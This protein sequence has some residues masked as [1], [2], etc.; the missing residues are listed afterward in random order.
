MKMLLIEDSAAD[1]ELTIAELR[2][3]GFEPECLRVES[4]EAIHAAMRG[5]TWSFV[6]SDFHLR[7]LHGHA[8]LEI[9][10]RYDAE[11]PFVIVSNS[12][13]EEHAAE[14][15][16]A[17]ASDYVM[18]D[19]LYRLGPIVERE[20]RDV[21]LRHERRMFFDAL[22]RSED[23]YRRIFEKAPIGVATT[24]THGDLIAVNERFASMLEHR[25]HE[26]IGRPLAAFVHPGDA[27]VT[28]AQQRA[29]QRYRTK[30]GDIVWTTVTAAEVYDGEAVLEQIVWLIEDISDQKR[31][32]LELERRA[33]QQTMVAN[34]GH[35]ALRGEPIE[36]LLEQITE[37][38]VDV[39]GVDY[40]GVLRESDG[41]FRRVNGIGWQ[42]GVVIEAD[43]M[44][45]A[46]YALDSAAPVVVRNLAEETRF[47]PPPALLENGIVSGVNVPIAMNQVAAWGVLGVYSRTE[48]SFTIHD[49]GFIRAMATVLAQAIERDRVNQELV[50]HAAQQSAI[51]A[52]TRVALNSIDE[53]IE[54]ACNFVQD[55]LDVERVAFLPPSQPAGIFG[56]RDLWEPVSSTSEHFGVLVAH[57][58]RN[59]AFTEP[60]FEFLRAIANI[61]ADAM[62]RERAARA[63]SISRERYREVVEGAS[64][65]IFT[66][67]P[68]DGTFLSL[69]AAFEQITGWPTSEWIGKSCLEIIAATH[70]DQARNLIEQLVNAQEPASGELRI[71][72]RHGDVLLDINSFPKVEDGR[73]LEI[74][75]FARN[76]TEARRAE[77]ERNEVTRRLQLVLAS[78]VEGIVTIDLAG[79]CTMWNAAATQILGR[80]ND[81]M[82]GETIHSLLHG[83]Y[84]ANATCDLTSTAANGD[85]QPVRKDVFS[86]ADGTVV[87]V[88][89]S[90]APV[91]DDGVTVG[92][93]L[94]FSDITERRNLEMKLDQAD[95]LTSLGRMAATIAHEFNNVL[96]GISPFVEVIRRGKSVETSLDHIAR[97]VKRGKRITDEI[98][99]FTRHEQPQRIAFDIKPWIDS[100]AL[101]ASSLVPANCRIETILHTPNLVID[102]DANQLQQIFTNLILNARDAMPNGGQ[103]TIEAC[104]EP[105]GARLPFGIVDH[106]ERF[107]HCIV[108][109]TGIGMSEETLRHLYEPLYTTKKNG[110]G[111]GLPLARQVVQRHG[112]DIFV[113]SQ[114]GVGTTFHIFLPL[115]SEAA[116]AAVLEPVVASN[117]LHVLLVEDDPSVA[118]GLAALLEMEGLHVDIVE[119]GEAAIAAIATNT[120]DVVVLDVGLPDMQGTK[121][122]AVIAETMP[123]LPV[124]F[125]TGHADR[126]ILDG[127]LELPNVSYLLKPYEGNALLKAIQEVLPN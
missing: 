45:M 105:H 9:V 3:F 62:E 25:P 7:E 101:E 78:T 92:V 58:K 29:E 63:L 110:T 109:D 39:L 113:E 77:N 12:M 66:L 42:E 83:Q 8:A 56:A 28:A 65:I 106:P 47:T 54:T 99:R 93:V 84:C 48:R 111:L 36:V 18:K 122:Y 82:D 71:K 4:A 97:A 17:G 15:I 41:R 61:L 38:V 98:L 96:M 32:K 118:S 22:R 76:V 90:A 104:R 68:E 94:N 70:R 81:E 26:M 87:P 107:A 23:R 86:R 73:T 37:A 75:G 127:L 2:R 51:A 126:A 95:R 21:Q 67:A 43:D 53:A 14:I 121:V 5:V 80:S 46:R 60:D 64:E 40:C 59:G 123:D 50:L 72:G 116:A 10:R 11:L 125:S 100:I 27:P 1:A 115:A 74:Y 117:A 49:V 69:N 91:V 13:G 31:Q 52:L 16:R 79:C 102:G 124:V 112:G 55:V 33:R 114:L 85:V 19:R 44:A 103:L 120:P 108:R 24:T 88:E 57:G 35:A 119:T 6:F 89:F 20:L 30:S 34:F